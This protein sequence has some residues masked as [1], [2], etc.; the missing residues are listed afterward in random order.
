MESLEGNG[1]PKAPLKSLEGLWAE[2]DIH[3]TEEDIAEMRREVWGNCP[4]EFPGE[5]IQSI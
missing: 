4:R 1:E 2:Y 5:A 3:I